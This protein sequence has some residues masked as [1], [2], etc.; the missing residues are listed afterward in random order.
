M[1]VTINIL[2]FAIVILILAGGWKMFL[3]AAKPGWGILIPIYNLVLML[4]IAGRPLW[5][6]ILL[7]IPLVNIVICIMVN[8]DI[9]KKFARGTGFGIGL[10]LLPFIF[11]PV[12]G[13]GKDQYQG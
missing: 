4:Q 12:L 1:R 6:L 11:I 5:W 10:A 9:A 2:Q 8:I 3:K 7:F 13:F